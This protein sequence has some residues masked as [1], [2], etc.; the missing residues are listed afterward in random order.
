MSIS[1]GEGTEKGE[2]EDCE[3][4]PAEEAPEADE[5]QQEA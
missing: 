4:R 2:R 1:K 3:R 5:W